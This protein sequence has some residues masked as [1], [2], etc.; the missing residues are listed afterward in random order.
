MLYVSLWM[1]TL[2]DHEPLSLSFLLLQV[3]SFVYKWHAH[4]HT[5]VVVYKSFPLTD[6]VSEELEFISIIMVNGIDS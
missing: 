2:Y 5:Q 4:T 6:R 1:S 3:Y